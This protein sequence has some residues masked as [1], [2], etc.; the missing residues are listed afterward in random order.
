MKSEN[1]KFKLIM[2][3]LIKT[4]IQIDNN[5]GKFTTILLNFFTQYLII[6]RTFTI[7][8]YSSD[9]TVSVSASTAICCPCSHDTGRHM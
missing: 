7:R 9:Y 8:D 6:F 5:S 1:Y 3:D 4:I 2:H